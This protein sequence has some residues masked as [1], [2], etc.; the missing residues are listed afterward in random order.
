M[1]LKGIKREDL[2][3]KNEKLVDDFISGASK[4]V[5]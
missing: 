4:N 2:T 3:S 5:Q 1:A